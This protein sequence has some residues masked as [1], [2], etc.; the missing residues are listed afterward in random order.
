MKNYIIA[1]VVLL[2]CMSGRVM[3][4]SL[5]GQ[6]SLGDEGPAQYATVYVPATGQGA[7]TDHEG[8][9]VLEN[10]PMG[11]VEVE[12]AFLGYNTVKR[13]LVIDEAKR[14][15]H[16]ECLDEQSFMLNDVYVTPTGEDP[17][18][19][20]L[21]KVAEKAAVNRKRLAHYE[22]GKEYVFHSQ[23]MDIAPAV[24]PKF[25]TWIMNSMMKMYHR[26]AIYEF[27]TGYE[28]TD[29]RLS[30]DMIFNQGNF[31]YKNEKMLS[32]S[33]SIP[34]KAQEQLFK[35][36][37]KDPFEV[38]YGDKTDYCSKMLKK[39]KCKYELKGSIEENGKVINVLVNE[40]AGDKDDPGVSTLYV[41]EDE[42]GIL[43]SEFKGK[44]SNIRVESR[45]VGGGIYLPVSYLDV[46]DLS[47][48]IYEKLIDEMETEYADK[49]ENGEFIASDKRKFHERVEEFNR[50]RGK[51]KPTIDIGYGISYR[52]VEIRK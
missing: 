11:T 19:Y 14:Y 6:V 10:V 32:A 4:Q 41:V 17:A 51:A 35:M 25:V 38:L 48:L 12:F 43:R 47:S 9:Y 46:T 28:R 42:W 39:G 52:G 26:G 23:D 8:R 1:L 27:C 21:R 22:A 34:S 30:S 33:P 15:A 40:H 24:L 37:Q 3:A 5:E 44:M 2:S 36:A 45:N 13:K 31:T 7:V 29:A 20:I 49:K 18:V 50:K 16:D